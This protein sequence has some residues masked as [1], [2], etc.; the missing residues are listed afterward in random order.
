MKLF[1]YSGK[2]P[3]LVPADCPAIFIERGSAIK[4]LEG[5]AKIVTG[6]GADFVPP[7]ARLVDRGT[8][9]AA[10][11][12]ASSVGVVSGNSGLVTFAGLCEQLGL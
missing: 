10:W 6:G 2:E 3:L 8:L 11:E 12:L 1:E 5:G 4:E 7:N 9:L